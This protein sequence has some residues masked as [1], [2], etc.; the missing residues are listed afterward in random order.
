MPT[1]SQLKR[2]IAKLPARRLF[3]R[4]IE[5]VKQCDSTNDELKQRIVA[6]ENMGPSKLA[7]AEN[8][9]IAIINED[10]TQKKKD[11]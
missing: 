7:K 9:G 8:L 2:L 3:A 1:S 4:D 10:N 11:Q 6:G 5:V